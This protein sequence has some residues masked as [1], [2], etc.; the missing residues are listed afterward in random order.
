MVTKQNRQQQKKK[1][2]SIFLDKLR[3]D[4]IAFRLDPEDSSKVE[5]YILSSNNKGKFDVLGS[6][7]IP[8]IIHPNLI[9]TSSK[10]EGFRSTLASR[11]GEMLLIAE[12]LFGKRDRSYSFLGFEFTDNG[13]NLHYEGNKSFI[14]R[15]QSG[16]MLEPMLVYAQMAHECV[17]ML[18]P[19]PQRPVTILEEG[20]AEFFA[21]IY[22][23]DTM[24]Y[25]LTSKQPGTA[26]HE[27]G[28]LV[29][30]L[31]SIN[32]YG[33]KQIREE[34]PT[35]SLIT[36]SL[37]WKHYPMLEEGVAARLARTFVPDDCQDPD[38]LAWYERET[39]MGKKSIDLMEENVGD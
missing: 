22:M 20:M 7:G 28:E 24:E 27:A 12:N 4:E 1:P 17:H 26:Y 29:A 31:M 30:M 23:R 2:Q 8:S 6:G 25:K 18:S 10:V 34:E 35:I 33:I 16:V 3:D 32:P 37:I 9:V 14:M 21:Y 11:L 36:K 5:S 13:P 15:I 19:C 39:Q 38:I